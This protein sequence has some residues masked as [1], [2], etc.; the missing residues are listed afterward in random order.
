MFAKSDNSFWVGF[1]PLLVLKVDM[2][3]DCVHREFFLY[4]AS[5]RDMSCPST[6][7]F[8]TEIAWSNSPCAGV[9]VTEGVGVGVLPDEGVGVATTGV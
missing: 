6:E 7:L 3:S 1:L 2:N 5:K 8:A 4:N 9:G